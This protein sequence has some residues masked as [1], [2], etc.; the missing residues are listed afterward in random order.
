MIPALG[1]LQL[2][3]LCRLVLHEAHDPA[4][5][6]RVREDVRREGVQ[7]NPVI[8]ASCK[9]LYLILDGA[10]RVHALRGLDVRFALVQWV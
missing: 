1:R 8:V 6:N 7:R 2:V 4:R 9:G 10:H 3:E 5:L